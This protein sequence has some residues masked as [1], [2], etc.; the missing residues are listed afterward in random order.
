[1]RGAIGE[2][3][4]VDDRLRAQNP[5]REAVL[6]VNESRPQININNVGVDQMNPLFWN[7]QGKREDEHLTIV[8]TRCAVGKPIASVE[9]TALC[10]HQHGI[11]W[12]Q[13]VCLPLVC[14]CVWRVC[15]HLRV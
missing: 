3:G 15:A 8:L 9:T 4:L 5:F 1:M 6:A 2:A 11:A 14:V 10:A 12:T 13:Q 7:E